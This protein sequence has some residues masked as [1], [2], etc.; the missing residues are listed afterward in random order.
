M[1]EPVTAAMQF[2]GIGTISA[3][4][5]E[6]MGVPL[7]PVFCAMAGALLGSGAIHDVSIIRA[8]GLYLA[9]VI[10]SA[11]LGHAAASHFLAGAAWA[12]NVLSF[13]IGAFFFPGLEIVAANL[14][15]IVARVLAR[16]GIDIEIP[17][18]K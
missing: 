11:L 4:T 12:A 8:V 1:K 9:A 2:A 10:G 15:L 7:P 18:A 14:K 17:G 6:L 16:I 5:V 13:L 3:L